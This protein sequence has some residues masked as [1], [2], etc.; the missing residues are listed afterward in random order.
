VAAQL[1]P[2]KVAEKQAAAAAKGHGQSLQSGTIE[3]KVP[4]GTLGIAGSVTVV[5]LR[6]ILGCLAG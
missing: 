6:A 3:I 5:T 1:L 4:R 2:V